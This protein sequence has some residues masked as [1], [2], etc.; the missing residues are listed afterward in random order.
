M[1]PDN[2]VA[3]VLNNVVLFLGAFILLFGLIKLLYVPLALI[4]S[5]LARRRRAKARWTYLDDQPSVSV[6]VPGYNEEAVIENCVSSIL[7]SNYP[8]LEVV[9]VD[10]G[11]TD[12]TAELMQRFSQEDPRV[13]FI[14]QENAGKGAALNHGT[15][16]SSG[17]VLMYVDSDGIFGPDTIEEML[18]GFNHSKVGAVC[19]DDRPV[20]LNTV[21][22][23][24]LTV[25]SHVGTGLVRRALT[26]LHCLPIVSGNVGAFRRDALALTGPLDEHTI[27]E[28]LEL[29]WRMHR[30]GFRVN[31]APR[32]LVHAESPSTIRG[33]WKQRV[34]WARGLL[35]TLQQHRRMVGNPRYGVFGVYLLINAIS[36]VV[37]PILQIVVLF[38]IP[39]L[40]LY[41]VNTLPTDMISVVLWLGL[42]V[43]LF[44]CL[45]AM[46]LN[47]SLGDVKYLW[48][49]PLWPIYSV[50]VGL[51]MIAALVQEITRRPS[52]WNKLERTGVVSIAR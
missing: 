11:S 13:R 43:S 38:C 2:S 46:T 28:D 18:R 25:I 27:G 15:R 34:R 47:K 49:M 23:R 41:R 50:F 45:Y 48:T 7:A 1:T 33:L 44:L 12:R 22:T 20:N 4:F 14:P 21:Q 37:I 51:T 6:V 40:L 17:E 19:G 32:A 52:V 36:M 35:Q 30:A 3:V 8:Y 5:Y 29:T 10:D 39:L 31:F 24:L 16:E 9:L 26:I 42:L